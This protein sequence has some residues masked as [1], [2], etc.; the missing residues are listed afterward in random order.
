M[1]ALIS[2]HWNEFMIQEI[3]RAEESSVLK[4]EVDELGQIQLAIHKLERAKLEVAYYSYAISKVINAMNLAAG[5]CEQPGRDHSKL[6][7]AT[8]K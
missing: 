6:L 3:V 7:F 5:L 1:Q 4:R 8:K 2:A